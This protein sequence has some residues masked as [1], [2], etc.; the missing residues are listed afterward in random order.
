M[1]ISVLIWHN[2]R[3]TT[4]DSAEHRFASRTNQLEHN[5]QLK[6]HS[7][8]TLLRGG[9]GLFAGSSH[10]DRVEFRH[11]VEAIDIEPGAL[12]I[13]G[14]GFAQIVPE[15]EIPAFIESVRG[16]GFPEFTLHPMGERELYSSI[17]FLEPFDWR[18]QR[19][20]GF[21]ML[22][23]SVRREAMLRACDTG[24]TAVC[25][26]ITLLQE[27]DEEVQA[28][29]LMYR[30]VYKHD[31]PIETVAERR[32]ALQGFMYSPFRMN[33]FMRDVYGGHA[34]VSLHIY[35]GALTQEDALM[36]DSVRMSPRGSDTVHTPL[37]TR[38][39]QI[40]EFGRSWKLVFQSLPE[41]EATVDSSK[42][43]MAL[44][45]GMLIS[46]LMV[47]VLVA[48][49]IAR[50]R[51]AA[52]R[53]AAKEVRKQKA[54]L[55]NIVST[56]PYAIFWKDR[57]FR[58]QG[59]NEVFARTVGADNPADL[60]GKEDR[61]IGLA[62][63]DAAQYRDIDRSVMESGK[64]VLHHEEVIHVDGTERWLST[65]KVPLLDDV[66]DIVGVLGIFEDI[67]LRKRVTAELE[68]AKAL[69]EDANRAKS[70][71]LAVMSHELRTPLNGVIGMTE[72]LLGTELNEQQRHHASLAKLSA[73]T[74]LA[75]INDILDF[76]KIEAGQLE[77]EAID[78]DIREAV[79]AVAISIGQRAEKKGIELV[80][81]VDP[82]MNTCRRGDPGRIQ[83]VL[84]NIASNAIKFTQTGEVVIEV[85]PEATS[86]DSDRIRVTVR[87]TGV[88]IPSNRINRLFRS[89]SQVD[90]STTREYGGTGLG[91]AICKQL[92]ELMGGEIG[93]ESTLGKG[94]TFWFTMELAARDGSAPQDERPDL[95]THHLLVVDDNETNRLLLA[96]HLK[97]LGIPYAT[98]SGP[99]E[100]LRLLRE[101]AEC[102]TPFDVA[103]LDMNMPEMNGIELAETIK[104]DTSIST[105]ALILLGS[106]HT[107]DIERLRAAEF[108]C[109]YSKPIRQSQV[110]K[111]I[112]EATKPST[113]E[114]SDHGRAMAPTRSTTIN[115]TGTTVLV[116]EDDEISQEVVAAMLKKAGCEYEIVPNGRA[117][118]EAAATRRFDLILM[119]GHMPV[120]DGLEAAR[121]I[122][123]HE[124]GSGGLARRGVRLPIVALTANVIKGDRERFLEAGMDDYLSKPIVSMRL[125]EVIDHFRQSHNQQE[126]HVSYE[127]SSVAE[128]PALD[129]AELLSRWKD[130]HDLAQR[131]LERF[132]IQ[133]PE[134]LA[135]LEE[136]VATSDAVRTKEAAHKLKGA[137]GYAA[138]AHVHRI[139]AELEGLG[140]RGEL[141]AAS[142]SLDVL[143]RE[144]N[145]CV[146]EMPAARKQVA[147]AQGSN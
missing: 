115:L 137:A 100:A 104:A 22:S 29:F 146:E 98:A 4:I 112:L 19:A 132:E 93:V 27:T 134:A 145:R 73:D 78:F 54:L 15:Q 85:R 49:A 30:P 46:V 2:T 75:L 35:D 142:G 108:A 123:A 50:A 64:P 65:S 143:R 51:S 89:F 52:A 88:G 92:V 96:E 61:E 57:E 9:V 124:E 44:V 69:A 110:S 109:W 118:V 25:G 10:V 70:D 40:N 45:G 105:V 74:L 91:L 23:H 141:E 66:G 71:F 120:M 103:F 72:L 76:S 58:L 90:A 11:F 14:I 125:L 39:T 34:V 126:N 128:G 79:E 36:Y 41:F 114:T 59:F 43:T 113:A 32:A 12:G 6:L 67:T 139:A 56:A 106:S 144:I 55:D 21:D 94:S 17:V 20:F 24:N 82:S 28:G 31:A 107:H 136:A 102:G 26:K 1:A 83:Q 127:K 87:D 138:A 5:L 63:S 133:A 48:T 97:T 7:V 147:A 130:M 116:A 37:L 84:L 62:E 131:V 42:A 122:R 121:T 68:A 81:F 38:T 16:E 3:H 47:G 86:R 99:E 8:D 53:A 129:V 77:L 18:N 111:Y 60:I 95:S 140:E 101:H 117:A 135:E 33:D 80:A 119:D 13:Q